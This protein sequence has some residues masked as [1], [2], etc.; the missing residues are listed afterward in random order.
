MRLVTLLLLLAVGACGDDALNALPNPPVE[1]KATTG[2]IAGRACDYS[3]GH[4]FVGVTAA[5]VVG[6]EL[7]TT[8]SD[9]SGEY[10]F[11]DLPPGT[12]E[13]QVTVPTG[14]EVWTTGV[15]AGAVAWVGPDTCAVPLGNLRGRA[16]NEQTGAWIAGAT[17]RLDDPAGTSTTADP[18]GRWVLPGLVAGDYLVTI[19]GP[20]Y[21]GTRTATVRPAETT[22]LGPLECRGAS[23]GVSG[24][25]CGAE[26]YWLSGASVRVVLGDGTMVETTTD[27]D[28]RYTLV[29]LPDGTHQVEV[30]RGSFNTSFSVTVS[31]GQ[32]THISDPVCI[33]PTATLAVV[34]GIYDKVQNVLTNLSFVV[35]GTYGPGGHVVQEPAGT[36]DLIQG[37]VSPY[38]LEEFLTDP[39]WMAEYDII[40]FNCGVNDDPI[41]FGEGVVTTAIANLRAFVAAGGSV[42][43]SDWASEILRLAF[44]G[45]INF[46]GSDSSFGAARLGLSNNALPATVVDQGL[47]TALARTNL[48][49]NLNLPEWVVLEPVPNQP[50]NLHILVTATVEACSNAYCFSTTDIQH[51]PL[52]V[53]FDD[54]AGRVLFT[55]AHN[56]AQTTQDLRDVLNYIIFEL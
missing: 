55:S 48:S 46:Q 7:R 31:G 2:T 38:W 1:P 52:V 35:R 27:A 33:P 51:S 16:C 18:S 3:T 34:T 23:G 56:E 29:G 54:G 15:T 26:G 13:V 20:S 21:N 14:V 22:D 6:G 10:R 39:A 49:I 9:E 8:T 37:D 24:R 45:R 17:V 40:F 5:L 4:W 47:A 42:Y 53:H 44:P 12:Y 36:V 32:I 43:A 41:Y 19:T 25:I 28:G 50:L 30:S 11:D